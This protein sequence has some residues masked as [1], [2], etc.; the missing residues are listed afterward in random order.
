M[1]PLVKVIR[2]GGFYLEHLKYDRSEVAHTLF[3]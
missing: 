1:K 2:D 3:Y